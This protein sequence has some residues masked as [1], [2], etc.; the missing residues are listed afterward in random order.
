MLTSDLGIR[1]MKIM[2]ENM[3]HLGHLTCH[4]LAGQLELEPWSAKPCL[5]YLVLFII[6]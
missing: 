5:A 2:L 3:M 6:E 1:R 4:V